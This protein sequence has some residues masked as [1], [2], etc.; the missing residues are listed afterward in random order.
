MT[1]VAFLMQ[2]RI[3]LLVVPSR[4]TNSTDYVTAW[5]ALMYY[6]LFFVLA[7]FVVAEFFKPKR[8]D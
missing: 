4:H 8:D 7:G 5:I 3:Y 6:V 1:S 2:R